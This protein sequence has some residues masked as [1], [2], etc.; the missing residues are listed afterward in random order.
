MDRNHMPWPDKIIV[1]CM[2]S[3]TI[4]VP[5]KECRTNKLL[6]IGR[7]PERSKSE[8]RSQSISPTNLPEPS[9]W[10]PSLL[11]DACATRKDPESE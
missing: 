10:N 1:T 4:G 8:R 9:H 5:G 7:I 11:S 6:P 2:S 3:L